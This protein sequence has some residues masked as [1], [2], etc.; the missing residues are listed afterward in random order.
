MI[1]RRIIRE[2]QLPG[3]VRIH[4]VDSSVLAAFDRLPREDDLLAVWR[5]RWRVVLD[6]S[7][8]DLDAPGTVRV[9]DVD[10]DL[11]GDAHAALAEGHALMVGRPRRSVVAARRELGGA[12]PVR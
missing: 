4:D 3:A 9:Q 10:V 5:P 11:S 8:R 6:R 7:G 1:V 12:R 2:L